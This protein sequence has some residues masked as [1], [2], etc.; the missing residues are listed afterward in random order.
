MSRIVADF[1]LRSRR[2]DIGKVLHGDRP[3]RILAAASSKYSPIVWP[4]HRKITIVNSGGNK[5]P[6][7]RSTARRNGPIRFGCITSSQFVASDVHDLFSISRF[8]PVLTAIISECPR[9]HHHGHPRRPRR[10]QRPGRLAA[11]GAC[12]QNIIHQQ[13]VGI[14]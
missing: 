6:S 11:R 4:T 9:R 13:H 14:P 2:A 5:M 1:R 3:R 7:P 8:E 12:R 10:S